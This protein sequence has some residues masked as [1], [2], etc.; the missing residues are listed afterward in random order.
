MAR[1]RPGNGS[2]AGLHRFALLGVLLGLSVASSSMADPSIPLRDT[3]VVWFADD[4]RPIPVPDFEEPGLVP[5]GYQSFIAR[6][7]SRFWNPGRA[8]RWAVTR[9]NVQEAA[10]LNALDEVVESTWFTNRIGMRSL[11]LRELAEG[12]G[13][14]NGL[15]AGPDRSAPWLV[16]G[17]K[18]A[19]VTP[20]FRIKDARGD[21]WLLKFDPPEH[22]GMTIRAGV[23]SNLLFHAMGF[24]VPVDRVVRFTLDDLTVGDDVSMRLNRGGEIALTEANLDSVLTA[25]GSV[26]SGEYHAL[27]SRYL[28]GVPLGPF[29]DQDRRK[30]DPN[31][32]VRHEN[33]RELRALQ[34]FGAWVNHFDTK[35]HNSLDMYV[36]EPGL[37]HVRHY[38]IDF[39]STL[40]AYGAE[41]VTRYGHEF[42]FDVFPII[43]RTLTLGLVNDAWAEQ[44]RPAGL[45]EIGLFDTESFK[46]QK[47]KPDLPNSQMAN[48]TRLDGYWA[49]KVIS[50]FTE[51]SL[52]V[53]VEQG[54]FQDPKSVEYLVNTLLAR[55]KAI[56]DYWFDRVPPLDYF[57]PVETGVAFQDLAVARGFLPR[58]GTLYRYRLAAV[59]SERHPAGWIDWRETDSP[60]IPLPSGADAQWRDVYATL[61]GDPQEQP[62]LAMD[63][64]VNRGDGWS[65]STTVYRAYGSGDIVALDR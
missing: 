65:P 22:P 5:Y 32:T 48:L 25:T 47:W 27:A 61:P 12:P 2:R 31:D 36:G 17:A 59:D 9:D 45:C 15:A 7:F 50:A 20:G 42:G 46:P 57:Q 55:Q 49:A 33:R 52:R 24:H 26:F 38:L 60:F 54:D 43:G 51:E 40:G 19:G 11:G 41:P 56:V 39:A 8:L 14:A 3:S 53:I 4:T 44:Q 23:V 34:V 62:F 35:A 58:A 16:V 63:C 1:I 18:T 10:D 37:G 28:D 64:Q 6:P 21:V 29:D 30:G 13:L